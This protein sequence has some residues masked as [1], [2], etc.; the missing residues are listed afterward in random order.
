M[1]KTLLCKSRC[2]VTC[3]ALTQKPCN[4]LPTTLLK[5]KLE[6]DTLYLFLSLEKRINKLSGKTKGQGVETL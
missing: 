6:T 4:I 3:N 1:P 2:A 5:L